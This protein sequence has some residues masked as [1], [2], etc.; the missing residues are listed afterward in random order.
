MTGK[1]SRAC[2]FC[3][4]S[5]P[6]KCTCLQSAEREWFEK[7]GVDFQ[8]GNRFFLTIGSFLLTVELFHLQLTILLFSHNWGFS[9]YSWGFF[10]YNAKVRLIRALR[11]CKQRSLAVSKKSQTVRK[12]ASPFSVWKPRETTRLNHDCPPFA[13]LRIP[14]FRG[15]HQ[16]HEMKSKTTLAQDPLFSAL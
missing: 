15:L 11:D 4:L 1:C 8:C 6:E 16:N 2:V 10:A 13:L 7:S 5:G 3:M 9:A 12:K 14:V